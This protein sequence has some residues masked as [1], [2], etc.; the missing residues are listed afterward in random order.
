MTQS[1]PVYTVTQVNTYIKSILDGDRSLSGI[2][3]RGEI[4]NYKKYPS[5][6]HYFTLK[7]QTGALRCVLFRSSALRLRFPARGRDEGGCPRQNHRFSQGRTV[8]AL[9][10]RADSRTEWGS[11]TWLL[12]S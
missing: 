12:S 10:G 3:I 9:C 7:D 1:R 5:G 8:P 4:S 2:Y 11:C 6:H